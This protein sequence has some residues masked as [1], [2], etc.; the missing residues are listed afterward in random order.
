M[1]KLYYEQTSE[2]KENSEKNLET[3]EQQLTHFLKTNILLK[4]LP[5]LH[6]DIKYQTMSVIQLLTL[7]TKNIENQLLDILTNNIEN[8]KIVTY[9]KYIHQKALEN[10]EIL[11]EELLPNQITKSKLKILEQTSFTT[12]EFY[13]N[14]NDLWKETIKWLYLLSTYYLIKYIRRLLEID[15][16]IVKKFKKDPEKLI[17]SSQIA[18]KIYHDKLKEINWIFTWSPIHELE[19]IQIM[20]LLILLTEN[21][22][23]EIKG[24][25]KNE[26]INF[27]TEIVK[28]A[29]IKKLDS[30]VKKILKDSKYRK[31]ITKELLVLSDQ[32]WF[33]KEFPTIEEVKWRALTIKQSIPPD[34]IIKQNDR[35][36]L[37]ENHSNKDT[38]LSKPFINF[39]FVDKLH[40]NIPLG[41]ISLRLTDDLSDIISKL[42]PREDYLIENWKIEI[43]NWTSFTKLSIE[44]IEKINHPI[45]KTS[46]D[47]RI[48]R[49]LLVDWKILWID[50]NWKPRIKPNFVEEFLEKR[51]SDFLIKFTKFLEENNVDTS[52]LKKHILEVKLAYYTKLLELVEK[53]IIDIAWEEIRYEI[54][55][56]NIYQIIPKNDEKRKLFKQEI[57]IF[58]VNQIEENYK[59]PPKDKVK[60]F[61]KNLSRK[62]NIPKI[63]LKQFDNDVT[64]IYRLYK[65]FFTLIFWNK[66]KK[67][68]FKTAIF[69]PILENKV[70]EL[71]LEL[72]K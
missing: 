56:L 19:K 70:K 68:L 21:F 9:L 5:E 17:E 1:K 26:A 54:N 38:N 11:L 47:I 15:K 14:T 36:I 25:N 34:I 29:R 64:K 10:T 60:R 72:N 57:S 59:R 58:F 66:E 27:L 53:A 13:E 35:W 30:I 71:K 37:K 43:K 50:K 20:E 65:K 52:S 40:P 55:E 23:I 12:I 39:S 31:Q 6:N 44:Q 46:Q 18:N 69:R 33:M 4:N 41:E 48:I 24:K 3:L 51:F 61:L 32:I 67:W 28:K 2:K 7:Q 42:T 16:I 49:K 62:L 63:P 45:Y 22:S 8:E